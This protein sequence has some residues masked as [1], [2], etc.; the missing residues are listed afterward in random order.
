MRNS[1][2]FSDHQAY[3]HETLSTSPNW[4]MKTV[5]ERVSSVVVKIWL[6]VMPVNTHYA[7]DIQYSI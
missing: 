3:N 6:V 4:A 2:A 1:K 5:T 7:L